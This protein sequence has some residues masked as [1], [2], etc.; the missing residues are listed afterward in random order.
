MARRG[1]EEEYEDG[2]EEEYEGNSLIEF[3]SSTSWR[4]AVVVPLILLLFGFGSWMMWKKYRDEVLNHSS[5]CLDPNNIQY[6]EEP[7][8]LPRKIL[9][10]VVKL[11]SLEAKKI[12][13][14]GLTVHVASAFEHH[15]W[16]KK[17]DRVVPYYP[18]KLVV[19]LSYRE[20]IAVVVRPFEADGKAWID[21]YPIDAEAVLLPSDDF[22]KERVREFPRIDVGNTLP[23][24]LAGS[25]WGDEMVADAAKIAHPDRLLGIQ[26]KSAEHVFHRFLQR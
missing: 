18:A 13:E 2:Y 20:P 14:Q 6:T 21:F 23:A 1:D 25:C 8:W 7:E 3:L 24:G 4:R 22:S 15:P 9:A 10:E 17:V 26:R 19:E 16:V 5:Y 11:G 12:N